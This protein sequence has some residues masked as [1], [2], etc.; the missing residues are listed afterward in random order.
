MDAGRAFDILLQIDRM[1][2]A[3]AQWSFDNS[4][5]GYNS[6]AFAAG[7]L[8]RLHLPNNLAALPMRNGAPH[9]GDLVRYGGGGYTM[10]YFRDSSKAGTQRDFVVGM[11]PFGVIALDM[12]FGVP[13]I[14]VRITG[15]SQ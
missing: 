11:T 6:P 4:R 1:R 14:E 10:F 7:V 9:P 12:D 15:L 2:L 5:G 8:D 3:G 13:I